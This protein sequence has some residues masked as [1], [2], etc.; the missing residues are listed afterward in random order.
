MK[1]NIYTKVCLISPKN[2]F[3]NDTQYDLMIR[4]AGSLENYLYVKSNER[5]EIWWH[6]G[7]Q[8]KK[9]QF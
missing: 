3:I 8:C 7:A 1:N 2:I 5:T 6:E 9:I 4:Q